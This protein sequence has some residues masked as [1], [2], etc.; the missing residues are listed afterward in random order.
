MDVVTE[1]LVQKIQEHTL[2]EEDVHGDEHNCDSNA[3]VESEGMAKQ[4][5]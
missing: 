1:T 5:C 4:Q 2:C 3:E